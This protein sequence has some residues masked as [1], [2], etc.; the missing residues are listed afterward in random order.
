MLESSPLR[1]PDEHEDRDERPARPARAPPAISRR[2]ALRPLALG[3]AHLGRLGPRGT[4]PG[5]SFA[6]IDLRSTFSLTD[7][8]LAERATGVSPSSPR[9]C[10]R[11]RGC[12]D[13]DEAVVAGHPVGPALDGRPV[14]LDGAPARAGRRGGGGGRC[15]SAGTP[16]RRRPCAARRPRPRRRASAATGRPSSARRAR[17][18]GAAGR[19][20]PGRVRKSSTSSS[21]ADTAARC[22][23]ERTAGPVLAIAMR[24]SSSG[25]TRP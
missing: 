17:R 22:R 4:G 18:G 23:V 8:E 3:L 11:S 12:A 21:S 2:V 6:T 15:C 24:P 7:R 10:R 13:V 16:S 5:L 9:R 19:A 14:D 20:P 25:L 1:P